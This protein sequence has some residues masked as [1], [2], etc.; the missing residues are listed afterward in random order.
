MLK[1]LLMVSAVALMGSVA[2][3]ATTSDQPG[4]FAGKHDHFRDAKQ[5]YATPVALDS[6]GV[7]RKPLHDHREMK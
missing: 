2:G 3:C 5:G 4:P 1:A 6:A 7:T